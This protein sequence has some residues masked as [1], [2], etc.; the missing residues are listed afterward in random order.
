MVFAFCLKK[1]IQASETKADVEFNFPKHEKCGLVS[2]TELFYFG[3][4]CY[5]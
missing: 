4:L 5:N 3:C 1:K 2:G